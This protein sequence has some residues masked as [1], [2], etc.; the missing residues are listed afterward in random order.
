MIKRTDRSATLAELD[1]NL[2]AGDLVVVSTDEYG[3]DI[4]EIGDVLPLLIEIPRI[5][6]IKRAIQLAPVYAAGPFKT[7]EAAKLFA[8]VKEAQEAIVQYY[9]TRG[10]Q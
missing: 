10:N 5:E 6:T 8:T 1:A 9:A 2:T 7:G 3:N 4:W